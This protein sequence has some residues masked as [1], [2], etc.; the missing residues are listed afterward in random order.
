M[1]V[2]T[3]DSVIVDLYS[4]T[5]QP[6]AVAFVATNLEPGKK[7]HLVVHTLGEANP[8]SLGA[9]VDLDGFVV[10]NSAL[11]STAV[12]GRGAGAL[13]SGEDPETPAGLVFSPIYP[14]PVS[15]RAMLRFALPQTGAVELDVMDVQGRHI[16]RLADG[17]YAPGDHAIA[18]EGRDSAGHRVGSG[19]YFAVLRFGGQVITHRMIVV[20]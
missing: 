8:L 14:N 17:T 18:W 12:H 7:H 16:T 11:Q 10:L 2:D 3:K 5:L 20:P 9:Q 1:K 15:S 6:A 19:V 13:S 4:P